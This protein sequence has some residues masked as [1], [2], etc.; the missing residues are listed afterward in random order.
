[1]N[2]MS[3]YHHLG[4]EVGRRAHFA[5]AVLDFYECVHLLSNSGILDEEAARVWR[6]SV[7]HELRNPNFLEHWRSQH[8]KGKSSNP[9][10]DLG[11]YHE[12][13]I[14]TIEDFVSSLPNSSRAGGLTKMVA[15]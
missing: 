12:K 2:Q 11:I 6:D 4:L 7:P 13:F 10:G 8:S 9:V 14:A 5:D 15:S 1:M 3:P